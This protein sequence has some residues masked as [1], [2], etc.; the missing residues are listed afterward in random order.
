MSNKKLPYNAKSGFKVPDNYFQELEAKLLESITS[1]V[2]AT[3]FTAVKR[4]PGFTVPANYFENLEAEVLRKTGSNLEKGKII[5][6]WDRKEV[7]YY[8][9][10]IAAVFIFIISTVLWK[11]SQTQIHTLEGIELTTLEKYIEEGYL[12]MNYNEI[13]AFISEE[14]FYINH[15]VTSDL[16]EE[17]VFEY[18]NETVEDPGLL[19]D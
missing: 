16:N 14:E 18:L 3:R 7:L 10:G 5:K 9:A 19:Y 17:D 12:D 6:L 2:K 8:V 11:P 15:M 13:S 1:Q 4:K